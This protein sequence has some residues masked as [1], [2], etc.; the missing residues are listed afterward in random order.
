[1]VSFNTTS[2]GIAVANQEIRGEVEQ[3]TP[4][5]PH[6]R[7]IHLCRGHSAVTANKRWAPPTER[8]RRRTNLRPSWDGADGARRPNRDKHANGW[9]SPEVLCIIS[10]SRS[11][12]FCTSDGKKISKCRQRWENNKIC[13]QN[14]KQIPL[15][16]QINMVPHSLLWT[17]DFMG[18]IS[19]RGYDNIRDP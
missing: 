12:P 19:Q 14:H 13:C 5:V 8:R 11:R 15:L 1:M 7:Q 6:P 3:G 4:Y 17:S 18:E 9:M 2:L 16:C 10:W